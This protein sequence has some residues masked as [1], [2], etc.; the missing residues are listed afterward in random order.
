MRN[1]KTGKIV[2]I[3]RRTGTARSV[4]WQGVYNFVADLADAKLNSA[5]YAKQ[6]RTLYDVLA[7]ETGD[8][9]LV[10]EFLLYQVSAQQHRG[11]ISKQ[12]RGLVAKLL[13]KSAPSGPGRGRTKG[14][15]GKASN[16]KKYKLYRDWIYEKTRNPSLTKERFAKLRLGITDEDLERDYSSVHR[17]KVDALLQDLKPARMKH[18]AEGQR[19]ALELVYPLMIMHPQYLAQ[20]WREAKQ[21]SPAS[22]KEDFLRAFFGWPRAG[23][24]HPIEAEMIRE[25]L[26]KLDHGEKLLTSSDRR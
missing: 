18:L 15:L 24:Q 26:E 12:C 16:D 21:H 5:D 25:Y 23:K 1:S 22:T 10:R 2:P 9:E 7:A 3:K 6:V 14:A 17:A 19:R 20:K 13:P 4:S 11:Q 8:A